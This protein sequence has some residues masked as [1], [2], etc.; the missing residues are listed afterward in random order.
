MAQPETHPTSAGLDRR[1]FVARLAGLGAA[2][3]VFPQ[4]L[5]AAVQEKGTLTRE[6]VLQAEKVAGL[7]LTDAQRDQ[8]L[9]GL[10]GLAGD[11]AKLRALDMPN[12]V[13]PA[14]RFGP[15]A[16][17]GPAQAARPPVSPPA[18]PDPPLP[19]S[20]EALAFLPLPDLHR[21]LV[22]RAVTSER[23]VRLS[24]HQLR[25]ADPVLHCVVALTEER[26]L[27][28]ARQAD[29]E[30]DRGRVR[31][32]LHGIPWGAK[33]L[34]AVRGYP[35]TWGA[36]PY[37]DQRFDEDAEVVRRLDEA[38]AV[39]VAKLSLGA[40]AMGDLWFGGRTRNPWKPD[41]G[42]SGSSAGSASAVAAGCVPFA[43]GTE[44]LGSIV[45]PSTRCG[46]TGLR[47]TFGRV[48]RTGAMAL[49][50][51]M[52][53]VGPIARG[54][55]DCALVLAAVQ[56]PDGRDADC[57]AAP[58]AW[59]PG[60][61]VR[62]MKVGIVRKAFDAEPEKE[63]GEPGAWTAEWKA[64]DAAALEVLTQLGVEWVDV[65]LPD[66]P[67]DAMTLLLLCEAAAAFDGLTRS[68]RD[69]L[70]TGQGDDDWPNLFRQA[71]LLPAVS[72]IQ[73]NRAR[74]LLVREAAA[75][76]A[77]VEA[78]VCPTFG[79]SNL[80]LTNLTG[81][82]QVVLPDGFKSDGTPTSFTFTGLPFGEARLLD[83]ASA[84]QRATGWHRRHP[85]VAG[86]EEATRG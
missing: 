20:D 25:T 42:S 56:G 3:T 62:G 7:T 77:G 40:L 15:L 48:P 28:Q 47:P 83:L 73:A 57:A 45:S 44:T 11:C 39:L 50:W 52:D 86:R 21:L 36:A 9:E 72:Y 49:S 2:A 10:N 8:L 26:A 1:A 6:V 23:L 5:L 16:I 51:S 68:G 85:A 78:Y 33:D 59:A 41:Q 12:D 38:G 14:L 54:V 24:L 80:S 60:A 74:T 17:P 31:G 79:A 82:P 84:Y 18:A 55:E 34:F 13:A 71:Q 30:L 66:L 65:E 29:E 67:V 27:A 4:V 35:T 58:F 53:K 22:K 19:D 63:G 43:L 81:H 75:R 70:L 61:S 76:L 32:P 69:A 64:N 46:A 37:K